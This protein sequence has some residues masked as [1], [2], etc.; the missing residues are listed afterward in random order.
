MGWVQLTL[1]VEAAD[2]ELVRSWLDD[3][4]VGG[5]EVRDGTAPMP[6]V[7]QPA[8]GRELLIAYFEKRQAALDALEKSRSL[9]TS[10]PELAGVPDKDW[11]TAWRRRVKA[12]SAGSLWVGP[13]WKKPKAKK[14]ALFIEPRMAFGT[15][16]HP[17]TWLCL[18]AVDAYVR[19]HPGCS[20][21]D[22][23]T[24]TGVL[25]LAAKKLGA[26]TVIGTD[27]DP[28]AVE[29]A[30][31]NARFNQ[32]R[33]VDFKLSTLGGLKRRFDLVVANILAHTLIDLAQPLAAKTGDRLVLSGVLATQRR[34]VERAFVATGLR[35]K[36]YAQRREWVRL[37]FERAR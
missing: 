31:E 7:R 4:G 20:V 29:Q 14:V 12:V 8:P 3:F 19:A 24:G 33:G 13:P 30:Q 21:L 28:I 1:E 5:V 23:G 27:N 17:T 25:S 11:S 37:D 35:S 9:S 18:S 26:G 2:G 15:G 10:P 36:G 6:R 16:D 22:V 32:V 34:D